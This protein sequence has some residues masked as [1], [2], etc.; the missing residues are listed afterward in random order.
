MFP[1]DFDMPSLPKMDTTI[2]FLFLKNESNRSNITEQWISLTIIATD[3]DEVSLSNQVHYMPVAR[4]RS[5]S[6]Y[7]HSMLIWELEWSISE[8]DQ[9]SRNPEKENADKL[10]PTNLTCAT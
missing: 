5:L 3:S 9:N 4:S 1:L 7:D 2:N 6:L 8:C 10:Q